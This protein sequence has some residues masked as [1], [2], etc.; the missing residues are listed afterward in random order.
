MRH[1]QFFLA[2]VTLIALALLFAAGRA[3]SRSIRSALGVGNASGTP[4]IAPTGARPPIATAADAEQSLRATDS[5]FIADVGLTESDIASTR[6]I[7]TFDSRLPNFAAGMSVFKTSLHGGG[8]CLTFVHPTTC[9]HVNPSAKEPLMG[10]GYDPDGERSGQPFVVISLRN[11]SVKSV[12]YVC[13]GSTYPASISGDVVTLIAPSSA[14][15][16]NDCS[17]QVTFANGQVQTKPV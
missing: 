10:L 13:A 8:F 9:T 6:A 16:L 1:K 15:S 7:Y 14:I 17:E 3:G 5:D 11:P 4:M 12:S 2:A